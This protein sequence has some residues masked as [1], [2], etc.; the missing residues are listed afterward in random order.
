MVR[1]NPFWLGEIRFGLVRLVF[2]RLEQF[3][4]RIGQ[5]WL[6][7]IPALPHSLINLKYILVLAGK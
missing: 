3:M 2:L 1:L 5:L 6:D 4:V 7:K